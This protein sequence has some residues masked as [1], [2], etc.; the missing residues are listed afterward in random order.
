M[1]PTL[2]RIF[3]LT[4]ARAIVLIVLA[5]WLAYANSLTKAFLLDDNIWILF[6][7]SLPSWWNNFWSSPRPTISLS[8][9]L[10][11]KL[12]GVHPVGYHLMNLLIHLAAALTLFGVLRRTMLLPRFGGAHENRATPLAF[13]VALLWVV[14]PINTHA[15]TY[16]IQRC[17]SLMGLCYVL[18]LY[19]LIRGSQSSRAWP[20]YV[21]SFAA[22]W[23]GMGA[24]EIV[25][26]APLVFLIY[27]RMFLADSWGELLRRR[28]VYYLAIATVPVRSVW[29]H[30]Y[31][32]LYPAGG[33]SAAFDIPGMEPHV[34]LYTETGVIWHYLRLAVW[35]VGLCFDYRDWPMTGTLREALPA[36]VPL[37]LLFLGSV[38]GVWRRHWLGFC[39][40]WF[41]LILGVTSSV[42]ALLDV[43]NEYR[44]YLPLMAVLA[45]LVIGGHSL[46]SRVWPAWTR[47]PALPASLLAAAAIILGTLTF[48]RNE[49]YRTS[50]SIWEDALEKRPRN[51]KVLNHIAASYELE[52]KYPEA[53]EAHEKCNAE[54]MK[55]FHQPFF[56]SLSSL[57]YLYYREGQRQKGLDCLERAVKLY[58]TQGEV[59]ATLAMYRHLEGDSL[60]ALKLYKVTQFVAPD[61]ALPYYGW[62]TVQMDLGNTDKAREAFAE[63]VEKFPAWPEKFHKLALLRLRGRYGDSEGAKRE[64]LFHAKT[65]VGSLGDGKTPEVLETLSD[66]YAWSGRRAE[67]LQAIDDAI[68]LAN[69]R[70]EEYR[71][72]LNAKRGRLSK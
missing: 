39:G 7:D 67:A 65:A 13:A 1:N 62:A 58:N 51:F 64:A 53:I 8:L 32:M 18:G 17:E 26:T 3:T 44:M 11:Y 35:P 16:V 59:N 29:H 50:M 61:K 37:T 4:P 33:Q 66:A 38:Y 23:V 9:T 5:G 72:E 48:L 2:S 69:D 46:A 40:M 31:H 30:V 54:F 21:G 68:A 49:D 47:V 45:V 19:C 36:A 34:Y 52:G 63:A 55:V 24:K 22:L 25:L 71:R 60:G 41:F 15:V 27:D 14:H 28:A 43:V 42:L 57:G 56:F 20:W 70:P 6:N 10:N 12:G